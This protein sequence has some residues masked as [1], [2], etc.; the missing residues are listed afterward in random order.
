ME[1]TPVYHKKTESGSWVINDA[2]TIIGDQVVRTKSSPRYLIDPAAVEAKRLI[3][4]GE[5]VLIAAH[6]QEQVDKYSQRLSEFEE[7][8]RATNDH[9]I[10]YGAWLD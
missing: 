2:I 8:G 6:L 4:A 9:H 7:S 5:P 10:N 1:F 3:D